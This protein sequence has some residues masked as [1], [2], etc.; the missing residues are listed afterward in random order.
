MS[1]LNPGNLTVVSAA[2]IS[3]GVNSCCVVI[4][5]KYGGLPSTFRPRASGTRKDPECRKT[6][7]Q[8]YSLFYF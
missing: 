2:R 3:S 6:G 5:L 7:K 1:R 8:K 4:C